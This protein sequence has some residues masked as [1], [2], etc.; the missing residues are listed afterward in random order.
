MGD[1][2]SEMEAGFIEGA[3]SNE[4]ASDFSSLSGGD[5]LPQG[6]EDAL[7]TLQG[8]QATLVCYR[9]SATFQL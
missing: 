5:S 4:L 9:Y 7:K 3:R 2:A 6:Y 1:V 8:M